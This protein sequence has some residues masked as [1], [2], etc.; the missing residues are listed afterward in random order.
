MQLH[1]QPDPT[2]TA[3]QAA[4]PIVPRNAGKFQIKVA[5]SA[6]DRKGEAVISQTN[7]TGDYTG[8]VVPAR[9]LYKKKLTWLLVGGAVAAA[10]IVIVVTR[11]SSSSSN[12]SNTVVITPGTPV[13][14]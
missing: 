5:A 14:Q 9:P 13:V 4:P 1:S 12:S 8:P 2:L 6:G 7:A 10:V 11:H 3:R